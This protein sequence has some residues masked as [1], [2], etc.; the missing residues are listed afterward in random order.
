MEYPQEL[1]DKHN[2]Y[3]LAPENTQ[4]PDEWLSLYQKS[5]ARDLNLGKDRTKKLLLTF[6]DKK[7]YV[8]HYRHLQLYLKLGMK[9]KKVHI[10]LSFDQKDWMEPYIR[11]NTEL[12]KKAASDFKKNFFKLM[13][14]SVFGKTTENL[15]NRT[16]VKLVRS[17]EEVK[18]QKLISHPLFARATVFGER[19]AGIQMHKDSI[20]MNRPVYTGMCVLDLSKTLMYEF[21]YFHLDYKYGP[22]CQFLYT[23]TDTDSLLL[24]IK[25]E[26]V[27]KDMEAS[28]SYYDTSDFP[29]DHPL[30]S[31]ENKKVIGKMEDESAGVP[32]SEVVC[33]RSKMYSILLGNDKN[34]R[35]AKGTTK[36]VTKKE[37]LHQNY[38]DAIFNKEAF[39]HGMDM[40]RSKDHQIYSVHL[41]K[42]TFS[43]IDSKRWNTDDGVHTLAYNYKDIGSN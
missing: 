3:P 7:K 40:L 27:Y 37:I 23:D 6:R 20:M 24:E 31:Q 39:K 18:F 22:R 30:H 9:L 12:R 25:T 13:N 29:K 14:N 11:L 41:N 15:R 32:I 17:N 33:L 8:L 21:Y 19:L 34:M 28:L 16:V 1:H 26:D 2:S 5:L 36:V 38:R 42:T 35:K 4:V 43:P 10:V